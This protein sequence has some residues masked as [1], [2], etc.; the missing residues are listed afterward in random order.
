MII[1]DFICSVV[2]CISRGAD[3]ALLTL[4]QVATRSVGTGALSGLRLRLL[5]LFER[6][7][8]GELLGDRHGMVKLLAGWDCAG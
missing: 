1:H 3:L 7:G 2:I 6:L 8:E 4:W 5:N